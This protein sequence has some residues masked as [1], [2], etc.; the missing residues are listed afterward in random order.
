MSKARLVITAVTVEGRPA[1]EVARTYGVGPLLDLRAAGRYGEEGEAAYEP[2]S[3][4]PK[5]S[6]RAIPDAT[7]SLI[8]D[9]RKELAG[10][11]RAGPGR[12]AA[13]DRLVPGTPLRHRGSHPRPSA[14]TWP[15]PG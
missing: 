10:L 11:G 13:D 8:I 6:P 15:A 12:R 14:A 5:T 7:V 3:Q 9:L 2:R 4:R 1:S